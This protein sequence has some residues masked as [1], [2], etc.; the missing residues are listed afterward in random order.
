MAASATPPFHN[1][2]YWYA[3]RS[4]YPDTQTIT[5]SDSLRG[6]LALGLD[7]PVALV[8]AT[9]RHLWLRNTGFLSL[10][11][12]VKSVP[13]KATLLEG[14]EF[15]EAREYRR[16]E[17]WE[18]AKEKG[19]SARLDGL[20]VWALAAGT[21]GDMQLRGADAV[22]FQRGEGFFENVERRRKGKGD[23]LPFWRGGPVW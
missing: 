22:R 1:L 21:T 20:G 14:V 12:D 7:F 18:K 13:W 5:F 19:W 2:L 10:N 16:Q 15:E 9:G 6:N 11:I 4:E 17:V 23:V 8:I 3:R